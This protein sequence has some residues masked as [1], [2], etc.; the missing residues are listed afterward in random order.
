[1][2]NV[3]A[4]IPARGGSKGVKRKNLCTV[5]G[6]SLVARAIN[7]AK[8]AKSILRCIVSTDD[9]EIASAAV[10]AGGDVPFMRPAELATDTASSV[11]VLIHAYEFCKRHDNV[12]Y[13]IVVLLQPTTPFRSGEDIDG[14]VE[15]LKA[16]PGHKSAVTIA[17]AEGCNPHY[18]YRYQ[19]DNAEI[20]PLL[21][22]DSVGERRQDLEKYYIRTGA[23]YAVMSS[24]LIGQHR[25]MGE[26]SL[27]YIVDAER[28]I[29]IDSQL[30]LIIA[31]QICL[32]YNF[33]S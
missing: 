14:T 28:S 16:S 2:K 23:V 31:N 29:N 10:E 5:G 20:L 11:D 3:L 26:N 13:D 1:M 21:I 6:V 25:V 19:S 24:Y 15:L 9:E 17:P 12:D 30:E 8:S 32:H 27:A 18:L 4:V 33:T 7:S 22:N